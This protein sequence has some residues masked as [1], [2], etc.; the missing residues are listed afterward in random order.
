G[1]GIE[2]LGRKRRV[3]LEKRRIR[4]RFGDRILE[5]AVP[6]DIDFRRL[7]ASCFLLCQPFRQEHRLNERGLANEIVK[8]LIPLSIESRAVSFSLV[9]N[10]TLYS[11][12][13][14]SLRSSEGISA[15]L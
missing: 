1:R 13:F 8:G 9:E 12:L 7:L 14:R 6:L 4:D 11:F 15:P 5:I 3:Q 10:R 2:H